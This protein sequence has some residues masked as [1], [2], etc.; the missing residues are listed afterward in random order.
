M[1]IY[2]KVKKLGAN[3]RKQV[4]HVLKPFLDFMDCFKLC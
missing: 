4:A 1:D 2:T 3:M